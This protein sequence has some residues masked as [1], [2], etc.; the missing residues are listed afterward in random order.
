MLLIVSTAS[1]KRERETP[2]KPLVDNSQIMNMEIKE[3][4]SGLKV[5]VSDVKETVE[6][7][8]KDSGLVKTGL[9]TTLKRR[10]I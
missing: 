5:E 2:L 9:T 3:K 7:K 1:F 10:K 4:D 8:E 6:I